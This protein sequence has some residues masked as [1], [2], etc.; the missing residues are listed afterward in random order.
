[1]G[2]ARRL[3][4]DDRLNLAME[5][6][7]TPMHVAAVVRC[8]RLALLDQPLLDQPLLD[9]PADAAR[10]E[11]QRAIGARMGRVPRLRQR[12]HRAG[13]FGP[14]EWV[15]DPAFRIERHVGL[16][17]GPVP[18]DETE[19]LRLAERL[20]AA[21]LDRRHP[22]WRAWFVP[23]MPNGGAA[24]IIVLHHVVADGSAAIGL[25]T[26]LLDDDPPPMSE[27]QTVHKGRPQRGID[28]LRGLWTGARH[29]LRAPRTSLNTPVTGRRSSTVLRF[30][31]A[32]VKGVA[33]QRQATVNDVMLALVANGLGAL[34][35]HRGEPTEGVH[36]HVAIPISRRTGAGRAEPGNQT[37]TAIVHLPV[38]AADPLSTLDVVR[39]E[40]A[41]VKR[42]QPPAA[43][44]A[45]MIWLART[46]VA[47]LLARRQH[48]TN[49]VVSNLAGPT[50]PIHVLGARV[51]EIVPIGILAGN[52]AINVLVLSYAGGITMTVRT[53]ERQHV[54]VDVLTDGITAAWAGLVATEVR[55]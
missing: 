14:L 8:D 22:L 37:G 52:L 41:E 48:M 54:D 16:A 21:P 33:H 7:D 17:P 47:R 46:G 42:T 49:L 9:Q 24:A 3:T 39:A 27:A 34:L 18:A 11:L 55:S 28:L 38:T 25:L 23:T 40:T 15:D 13:P 50:A 36:L 5:A 32:A 44:Q 6:P 30:D 2:T 12:L 51:R 35:R 1:M 26:T 53:D 10:R 45:I 29:A 4:P 43:G 20:I 31:L 19:L